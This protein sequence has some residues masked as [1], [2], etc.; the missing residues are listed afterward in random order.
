MTGWTVLVTGGAGYIGSHSIIELMSAGH[1][2]IVVDSFVNAR[3]ECLKRVESIVGRSI[4]AYHID[5]RNEAQLS[6]VFQKH[7]IDAVIHFAALKA[8]GESVSKPLMYYENNLIGTISLLKA[9]SNHG[10][11][12]LVFSSSATVYGTPQYLPL[13]ERHPVGGCTNPYGKTKLMMEEIL[14]DLQS[15]EPD[16]SVVVLRYFNPIGAHKSGTIGEDPNGVPNNLMPYVSQVAVGRRPE[17]TVFGNKYDTPDGT[18]VRDYIHVCDL[19][20]GHVA[21]LAKLQ[22]SGFRVYNLGTGKGCSVLELIKAMEA[23]SGRPIPYKIG[24]A[25]AGDV[26]SVYSDPSLAAAELNWRAERGL[27][28]MCADSWRWQSINPNGFDSSA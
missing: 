25:R 6:E 23:A 22:Q 14:R 26:A 4:P 2:V 28:E 20:S 24:P 8:V 12:R 17:V 21:A 27:D 11:K 13:D 9:M 10:V 19:A 7:T 15:A 18:G 3:S 1:E 16:W 5:I